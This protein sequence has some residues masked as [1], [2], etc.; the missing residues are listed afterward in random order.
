MSGKRLH[1]HANL[2][3]LV[4]AIFAILTG[5]S[6]FLRFSVHAAAHV[7]QSRRM[8]TAAKSS[9]VQAGEGIWPFSAAR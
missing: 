1:S 6:V 4:V 2:G 7:P 3:H 9:E 5:V 8:E